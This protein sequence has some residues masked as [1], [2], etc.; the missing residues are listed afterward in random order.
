LAALQSLRISRAE[1][2][3]DKPLPY[4]S[5]LSL[6]ETAGGDEPLPYKSSACGLKLRSTPRSAR[7]RNA[8]GGCL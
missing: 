4:K 1:H 3:W 2:W 8:P 7:S 5:C 6:N